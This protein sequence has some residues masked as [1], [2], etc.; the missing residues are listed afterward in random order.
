MLCV[1]REPRTC[2]LSG[3]QDLCDSGHVTSWTVRYIM[4]YL[5]HRA[6]VGVTGLTTIPPGE[7]HDTMLM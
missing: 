7:L 4:F 6:D 2:L 5:P 1:P 3:P